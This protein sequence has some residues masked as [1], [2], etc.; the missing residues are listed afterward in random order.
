VVG[1]ASGAG[2]PAG[3]VALDAAEVGATAAVADVAVGPD[4]VLRLA[5]DAEPRERLPVDIVEDAGPD[6]AGK[7]VH[8][9]EAAV[10]L[11]QSGEVGCVPTVG[12]SAEEEVKSRC[13]YS[14]L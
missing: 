5:V 2:E 6:I 13:G 9:D 8:G 1:L 10:A 14:V 3:E 7:P 4:Q 12:G 11:P